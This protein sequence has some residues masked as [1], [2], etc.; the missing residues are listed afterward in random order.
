MTDVHTD[1][2]EDDEFDTILPPD[3]DFSG[4][5]NF[6][7]SFLIQGKISGKI[8]ARGVLVIDRD[9]VVDADISAS[10]V[11]IRGSVTGNITASEKVELSGTGRLQ[12]DIVA[13]KIMMESGCSFNGQCTMAETAL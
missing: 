9:A 4:T 3:I 8:D 2:L 7:K 10:R 5:L 11:V 13:P 12:G 6:E 1:T